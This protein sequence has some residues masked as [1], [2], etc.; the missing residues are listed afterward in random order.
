MDRQYLAVA[1]TS[2]YGSTHSAED[3]SEVFAAY[4]KGKDLSRD[5]LE[6]FKSVL[7]RKHRSALTVLVRAVTA[8]LG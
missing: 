1:A 7:G 5:Q 2:T 3:F 4:V 6:R 8:L